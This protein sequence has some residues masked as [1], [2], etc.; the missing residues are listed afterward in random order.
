[1]TSL[2]RVKKF[3]QKREMRYFVA[4]IVEGTDLTQGQIP[5]ADSGNYHLGNLPDNALVVDAFVQVISASD[6]ATS[7]D[8]TLGTASAGSQILSAIDLTAT[9][10]DG[11]Y[12]GNSLTGSGKEVWFN[13][14]TVGAA[15]DVGEYLVVIA[16]LEY[17]MTNGEYTSTAEAA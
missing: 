10:K 14:T 8:A 4:H 9:G 17:E 12:T 6:A 11:T 3:A 1:M 16:Y 2:V 7:S 5:S 15:T 13:K